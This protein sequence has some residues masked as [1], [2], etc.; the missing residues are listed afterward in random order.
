MSHH[1]TMNGIRRGKR[2]D[3]FSHDQ[4]MTS[5]FS[6]LKWHVLVACLVLD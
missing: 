5:V 6:G 2:L 1:S 4:S 3:V